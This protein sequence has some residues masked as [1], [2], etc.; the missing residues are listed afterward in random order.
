MF[1]I[2][3]FSVACLSPLQTVVMA[4][5]ENDKSPETQLRFWNHWHARQPTAKQ[6]VIDVGKFIKICC[7]PVQRH[8]LEWEKQ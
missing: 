4:V 5:F 8:V 3:C 1:L 6:R 2:R 7:A